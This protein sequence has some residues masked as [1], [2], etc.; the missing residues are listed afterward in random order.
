MASDQLPVVIEPGRLTTQTDTYIVPAL[1]ADLGEPASWRYVE[2]FTANIRNANTRR[3]YV[4]ACTR[5]LTWCEER[6]LT[7]TT[8]RPHDVATYIEERQRSHSAPDVKQ[9]LAAVRQMFDWLITGQIVPVN[10]AAAVRGPK[11]VVKT[12]KTAVLVPPVAAPASYGRYSRIADGTGSRWEPA[13]RSG[14]VRRP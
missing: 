4:R 6:G 11:H 5:F 12:G 7:L 1:V 10:P 2:F 3:A 13:G 14:P 8:I 9:Q